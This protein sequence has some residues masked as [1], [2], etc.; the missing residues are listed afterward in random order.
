MGFLVVSLTFSMYNIMHVTCT[1]LL[2]PFQF[3]FLS[4][5]C[6]IAATG[7]FST[8]LNKSNESAFSFSSLCVVLDMGRNYRSIRVLGLDT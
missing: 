4:F 7:T 5:S 2:L 6:V 1:I 8:V 3:G